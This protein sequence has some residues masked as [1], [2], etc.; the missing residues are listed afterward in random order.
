MKGTIQRVVKASVEVDG[1][2]I[3]TIGRGICVLVGIHKNDTEKDKEYLTRKLL[4]IR[5][6]ED[7]KGRRWSRS[8]TD[9]QY[10]ILCVSQFTLYYYLKGNKPDF[11]A[12]MPGAQS[13]EFYYSFLDML[14]RQYDPSKIKDGQFGAMMQVH[15]QNDGPVTLDLES[16]TLRQLLNDQEKKPEDGK[17]GTVSSPDSEVA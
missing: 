14:R 5:L 15:I 6:W 17:K 13:Q 9:M 10:E 1:Q 11:H 2:V 16:P 3:S 4:S 7:E 8:V 12:A